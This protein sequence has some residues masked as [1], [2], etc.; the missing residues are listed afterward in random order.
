M[1]QKATCPACEQLPEKPGVAGTL[2]VS[3]PV[4]HTR[5]KIQKIAEGQALTVDDATQG[6]LGISVTPDQLDALLAELSGQLSEPERDESNALFLEQGN[7][8]SVQAL[9]QA[10]PLSVLMGQR[11]G[12]WLVDLM[13]RDQLFMHFHPIVSTQNPAQIHAHE[14]LLRASDEE[15]RVISPA[16]LFGAADQAGLMFHL[17]RAARLTAIRDATKNGLQDKIFINFNPT[18]IYDPTFCLQTTVRAIEDVGIP[19][20]RLVFEVI[21]SEEVRDKDHLL[22]IL[23]FYRKAG[24]GVA[25]DDLGA[26]Y[27]SLNLLSALRPD[28]VKF[29]RQLVSEIDLNPYKQ[30]VFDKLVEMSSDLGIKI[31]AEGVER[32][33]EWAFL[34]ERGVDYAQGFLFCKPD[35]PP[36]QPRDPEK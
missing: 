6:V 28:Y 20:E 33:E 2:Y 19:P 36:Q 31:V 3:P 10:R 29:D 17:D 14:C 24:F 8:L 7:T 23:D 11:E 21:E 32:V 18:A 13:E 15:G 4:P 16:R 25:L 22:S 35:T 9:L 27:A 30:K 34:K 26:G 12:E 1:N 5:K